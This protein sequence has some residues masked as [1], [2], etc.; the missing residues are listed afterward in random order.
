M[1]NEDL[2]KLQVVASIDT[3]SIRTPDNDLLL[4]DAAEDTGH[5]KDGITSIK[6]NP[7]KFAGYEVYSFSDYR[8]QM[9]QILDGSGINQFWYSRVDFRFDSY[10]PEGRYQEMEKINRALILSYYC[11]HPDIRDNL[12]ET[13][14]AWNRKRLSICYRANTVQLEYYN[15]EEQEKSGTVLSRLELRNTRLGELKDTFPLDRPYHLAQVWKAQLVGCVAAYEDMQHGQ[16]VE[17]YRQYID[18]MEKGIY[19]N[20][21]DFV[22]KNIE[23]IFSGKQMEEL[24]AMM[25]AANPKNARYNFVTRHKNLDVKFIKVKDM[26]RYVKYLCSCLDNFLLDSVRSDEKCESLH[27]A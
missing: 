3:L 19:N 13:R 4:P 24:F 17:L 9:R 15:K 12:Y 18:G 7:N 1:T 10:Q 22:Q 14:H 6:I 21:S 2:S 25:G 20:S 8:Q 26:E 27:I 11:Q 5:S 23:Y 16:N